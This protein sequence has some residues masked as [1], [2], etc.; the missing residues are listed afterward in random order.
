MAQRPLRN[1]GQMELPP[2]PIPSAS[3]APSGRIHAGKMQL[4]NKMGT[5]KSSPFGGSGYPAPPPPHHFLTISR[6]LPIF[7]CT[8]Q[9]LQNRFSTPRYGCVCPT[10]SGLLEDCPRYQALHT[11]HDKPV[12]TAYRIKYAVAYSRYVVALLLLKQ[13]KTPPKGGIILRGWVRRTVFRMS[14]SPETLEVTCL[15]LENHP[16]L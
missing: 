4:S 7:P 9:A 8:S 15:A 13:G 3:R 16:G 1:A 6:S 11:A 2:S 14:F 12:T 10:P 5:Q